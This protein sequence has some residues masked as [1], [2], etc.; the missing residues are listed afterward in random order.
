MISVYVFKY[1]HKRFSMIIFALKHLL[2]FL[3]SYCMNPVLL[4]YCDIHLL[5]E[6]N[7]SL[8]TRYTSK[9]LWLTFGTWRSC[10]CPV[11]ILYAPELFISFFPLL[12]TIMYGNKNRYSLAWEN[13]LNISIHQTTV[14]CDALSYTKT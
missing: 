5:S 4:R 13:I 11:F 9:L 6:H 7:E 12:S 14:L 3:Q 8:F 1:I 2:H 10:W